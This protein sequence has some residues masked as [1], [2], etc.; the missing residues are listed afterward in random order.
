[1]TAETELHAGQ[2]HDHRV[3]WAV[4]GPVAVDQPSGADQ[5][6]GIVSR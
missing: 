6:L 4:G 1:M 3:V 5:N 2:L